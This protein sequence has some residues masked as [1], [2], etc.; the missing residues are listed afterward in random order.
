MIVYRKDTSREPE[1]RADCVCTCLALAKAFGCRR[2]T[3]AGFE[4]RRMAKVGRRTHF[5]NG[6]EVWPPTNS[7]CARR[8]TARAPQPSLVPFIFPS[9]FRHCFREGELPPTSCPAAT[10]L[11]RGT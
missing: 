3:A 9:S 2:A 10:A 1:K 8:C 5:R 7:E 6:C 4:R 11:A